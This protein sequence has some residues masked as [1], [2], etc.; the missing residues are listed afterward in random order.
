MPDSCRLDS[1]RKTA[2]PGRKDYGRNIRGARKA[3]KLMKTV[4]WKNRQRALKAWYTRRDR[5]RHALAWITVQKRLYGYVAVA[6]RL[7]VDQTRILKK[8]GAL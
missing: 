7:T 1:D 6:D 8:A 4:A 2:K 3:W 5:A